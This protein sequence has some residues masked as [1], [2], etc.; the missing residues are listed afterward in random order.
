MNRLPGALPRLRQAVLPGALRS[1]PASAQQIRHSSKKSLARGKRLRRGG[2][3]P[4]AFPLGKSTAD[5]VDRTQHINPKIRTPTPVVNPIDRWRILRGDNVEIISGRYTGQRGV[6]KEVMR[7]SNSVLIEGCAVEQMKI[8]GEGGEKKTIK[9]EQPVYVSRCAVVC[10][11]TNKPTRVTFAFAEDGTKVRVSKRSG[12]V[13]PR[14]EILS[15]RRK[16]RS[17]EGP[18]D[19]PATVVLHRSFEDEDGLY[20]RYQGFKQLIDSTPS[21]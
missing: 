9:T 3:V 15:K 20:E 5:I 17:P 19:T 12:A 10:P 13:I 8:D 21:P 6:V 2:P 4:G 18:K 7:A 14:P 11:V 16:E 1:Y